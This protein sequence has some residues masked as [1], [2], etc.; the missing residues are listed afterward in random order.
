MFSGGQIT[1]QH[2]V[3]RADPHRLMDGLQFRGVGDGIS[4]HEGV[5]VAGFKQPA[6]HGDGGGFA[7]AVGALWERRKGRRKEG[8]WFWRKLCIVVNPQGWHRIEWETR[9]FALIKKRGT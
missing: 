5:S 3:L 4:V 7:G 1:P 6:Q 2:V 9:M 8:Q